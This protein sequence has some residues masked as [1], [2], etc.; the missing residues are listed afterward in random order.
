[1]KPDPAA[2]VRICYKRWNRLG[3][4]PREA[5]EEMAAIFHL[6]VKLDEVR[7]LDGA[8][9]RTERTDHAG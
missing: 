7:Q 3:L 6:S 9:R 8:M 1:M 2:L 5:M 4:T